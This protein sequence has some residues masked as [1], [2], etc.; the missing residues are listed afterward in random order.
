[1]K[2]I[3]VLQVMRDVLLCMV[4]AEENFFWLKLSLLQKEKNNCT[5]NQ[6]SLE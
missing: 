6:N 1:M 2:G 4:Y 3:F 5:L